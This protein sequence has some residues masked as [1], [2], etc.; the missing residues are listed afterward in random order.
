MARFTSRPH[1]LILRDRPWLS[2]GL[3]CALI[4]G[5]TIPLMVMGTNELDCHR[6][7]ANDGECHLRDS[8][9]WGSQSRTI[10]LAI[11][12]GAWVEQLGSERVNRGYQTKLQTRDGSINVGDHTGFREW[13]ENLA[14]EI[15]LFLEEPG[16]AELFARQD[17]RWLGWIFLVLFPS[18][19]IV[20]ILGFSKVGIVDFDQSLG[21]LTM[22]YQGVFSRQ[23]SQYPLN[24][25]QAIELKPSSA[26][27]GSPEILVIQDSGKRISLDPLCRGSLMQQKQTVA[28]IRNFLG[29]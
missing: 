12:E 7:S 4:L 16:Q 18:I 27:K 3:G 22:G 9:L 17:D 25:I 23:L 6:T 2:W 21:T 11:I 10:P 24:H 8:H 1:R 28:Q 13:H 20:W 29:L 26:P 5:G 15:N 14:Q 19:G